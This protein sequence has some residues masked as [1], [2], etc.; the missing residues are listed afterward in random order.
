MLKLKLLITIFSLFI[1]SCSDKIVEETTERWENHIPKT[2][3]YYIGD[4]GEQEIFK[5]VSYYENG[6]IEKEENY[7]PKE[8]NNAEYTQGSTRVTYQPYECIWY[9]EENGQVRLKGNFIQV[10]EESYY[11]NIRHSNIRHGDWVWYYENG[12]VRLKG[13]YERGY[14][15]GQRVSYYE[16][17]QKA[18][19][20]SF[21]PRY[22]RK[23]DAPPQEVCDCDWQEKKALENEKDYYLDCC[24][25]GQWFTFYENGQIEEETNYKDGKK[26]G[27]QIRY[28]NTGQIMS[29]SAYKDGKKIY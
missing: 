4:G 11:S 25:D 17:G 2:V 20:K 10:F 22:I 16:N 12:Q 8:G 15:N 6:Q 19:V 5:I 27:K 24:Y 26:D 14:S 28:Y 9:Y 21:L 13:N 3:K 18:S 23:E 29:E 1:I 7:K